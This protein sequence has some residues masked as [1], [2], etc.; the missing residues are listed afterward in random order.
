[1]I[2]TSPRRRALF[3]IMLRRLPHLRCK[4]AVAGASCSR[5]LLRAML[6]NDRWSL[7]FVSRSL[8][9]SEGLDQFDGGEEAGVLLVM[10]DGL[11]TKCCGDVRLA[12]VRLSERA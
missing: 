7:D 10:F 3:I 9:L 12:S 4:G 5:A 6:P 2:N 1:M 8:F 11:H